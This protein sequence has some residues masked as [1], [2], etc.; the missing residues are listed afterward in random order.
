[1]PDPATTYNLSKAVWPGKSPRRAAGQP[2]LTFTE[3][4][5]KLH[6]DPAS[7]LNTITG[8]GDGYI[9]VNRSPHEH[10]VVFGPEGDVRRWAPATFDEIDAAALAHAVDLTSKP[11]PEVFLIGTGARQRFLA[12]GLLRPLLKAGVGVEMM[13]SQAASRTYNILMAEGRRV[14]VALLLA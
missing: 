12:A 5:L 8:Y 11:L 1:M 4:N 6:S 14:M 10:A 13:D 2:P 3:L 7:A 9:E